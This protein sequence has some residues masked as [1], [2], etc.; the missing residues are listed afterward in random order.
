MI[1]IK[2][3][4]LLV[5]FLSSLYIGILIS[6]KYISREKELKEMK[7]ALNMFETKMKF[8]YESVPEIFKEISNKTQNNIR[9]IFSKASK[10]ME[11]SSAGEA[12]IYS[13]EN[14]NTNMTKEDKD[15]LKNLGKLL[16]KTDIEGQISEI[17]LVNEFLDRQIEIAQNE[18]S[19]NEKMYKT[20]GGVIGLAL[21]IVFI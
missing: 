13:L 3:P 10:I 17:K 20:L 1:Y 18:R 2:L 15:I 14:T 16:G 9:E 5:I 4:I 11:Q 12:W 8:T 21:A 6:K 19:K 7:N